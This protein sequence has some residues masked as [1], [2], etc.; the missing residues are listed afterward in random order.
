MVDDGVP[1]MGRTG[2]IEGK[3]AAVRVVDGDH[4][5]RYTGGPGPGYLSYW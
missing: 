1:L 2:R 3:D 5:S 4:G